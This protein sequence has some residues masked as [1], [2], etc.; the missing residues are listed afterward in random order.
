[1]GDERGLHL[2]GRDP[3]PAHLEHV[4]GPAA[5]LVVPVGI[6]LELVAGACPLTGERRS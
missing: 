1:M 4:V 5:V 6:A 2:E 3:D